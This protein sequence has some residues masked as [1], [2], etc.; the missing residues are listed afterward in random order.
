MSRLKSVQGALAYSTA[1]ALKSTRSETT[2]Y[3]RRHSIPSANRCSSIPCAVRKGAYWNTR[4]LHVESQH[5]LWTSGP[6]NLCGDPTQPHTHGSPHVH[7]GQSCMVI[8]L[9]RVVE[10]F[11]RW[12]THEQGEAQGC[13]K[14]CGIFSNIQG[15]IPARFLATPCK[16]SCPPL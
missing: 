2:A 10:G 13:K 12:R 3:G 11:S 16:L 5:V 15:C 6:N 7:T 4:V 9:R 1:F 8:S 14:T